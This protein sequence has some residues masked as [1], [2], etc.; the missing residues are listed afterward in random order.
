MTPAHRRYFAIEMAIAAVINAVLSAGFVFLVF[1]GQDRVTVLGLSGLVV[2]AAPQSFMV[3]LMS[4]LVP[5]LLTRRRVAAGAVA[6]MPRV[7][8]V[9]RRLAVR[10]FVL[11]ATTAILAVAVQAVLLPRFGQVWSFRCVLAF[12]CVYGAFVGAG[13]AALSIRL[14]LGDERARPML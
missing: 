13:I 11:A 4:C 2:D 7:F 14:A 1:G 5:T 6:P 3:A 10:A 8:D 12:K 9:S